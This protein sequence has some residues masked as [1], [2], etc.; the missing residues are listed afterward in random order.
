MCCRLPSEDRNSPSRSTSSL[1]TSTRRS[2]LE[3]EKKRDRLLRGAARRRRRNRDRRESREV[4]PAQG[5]RDPPQRVRRQG[6]ARESARRIS[7]ARRAAMCR[8]CA[9]R[10]A[11]RR[12]ARSGFKLQDI[13]RID[14]I[15]IAPQR[16]DARDAEPRCGRRATAAASARAGRC[17]GRVSP[18]RSIE[19][20]ATLEHS[21][22]RALRQST[23]ASPASA[24]KRVARKREATVGEPSRFARAAEDRRICAPS[25]MTKSC[26]R[27][28]DAALRRRQ[29]QRMRASAG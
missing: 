20:A 29:A 13:L 27:L 3:G 4:S 14:R 9:A 12:A 22:R 11:R 19:R 10:R 23:K 21:A 1:A 8:Y 2:A 25:A 26:A 15:R 24:A 16:L 7:P 28:A 6:A 17:G 18:G 5:E